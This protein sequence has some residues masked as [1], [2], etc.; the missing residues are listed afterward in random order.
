MEAAASAQLPIVER[1][2]TPAEAMKAREAFL[3]AATAGVTPIVAI[4]GKKV[5]DGKPG[6]LT[7]RIQELY[8][9]A[10]RKAVEGKSAAA[11]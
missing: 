2:F 9:L 6:T 11:E 5:A 1:K 7:R 3:T 10:A 4:D 8:A